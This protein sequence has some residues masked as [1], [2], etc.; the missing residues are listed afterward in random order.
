MSD[1]MTEPTT[2]TKS[3]LFAAMG[4]AL[5]REARLLSLTKPVAFRSP[6]HVQGKDRTIK[7]CPEMTVVCVRIAGRDPNRVAGDMIDGVIAANDIAGTE[8]E[9]PARARL[10][11]AAGEA[12]AA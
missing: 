1:T 3:L 5:Q 6:P 12:L 9:G 2:T 10:W 7:R 11:E 8:A 4:R